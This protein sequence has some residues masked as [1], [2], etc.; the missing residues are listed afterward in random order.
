MMLK[1]K[2]IL[3]TGATK[4]IGRSLVSKLE[5][6]PNVRFALVARSSELLSELQEHLQRQGHEC[7]IFAGDVAA[8][9]F[10]ISTVQRVVERFGSI[11]I[12]VNNAGIG[13]FGEVEGYSLGEWQ[14]LF[15][16]NVTGTFLFSREVVPHMKQQGRGHIVMVASD[17]S[18]RVFEGGSAYCATKFAQD[19]FSMA[20]RKEVRR[21]GIKV[22]T[23]F[24]GLVDTEFHAEPEGDPTHQKWLRA[25]D[26]A[27]AIFYVLCAPPHVVID[28]LMLHPMIQEY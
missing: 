17:V 18:K 20:L 16:T 3:I 25:H 9:P 23:I 26:V 24:P 5:T 11:D 7:E 2:T 4:G 22:S 27:D 19:A 14:Q 10:V 1:E 12:L 8:E 13:R 28:E 6:Q 15:D 21:F